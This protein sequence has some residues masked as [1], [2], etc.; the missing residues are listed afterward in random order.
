MM[1]M[2]MILKLNGNLMKKSNNMIK[3]N[4][5]MKMKIRQNQIGVKILIKKVVKIM[6][7][8]IWKSHLIQDLMKQLT[9]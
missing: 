9:K 6:V 7:V 3:I 4:K 1:K 8:W 5:K 2:K